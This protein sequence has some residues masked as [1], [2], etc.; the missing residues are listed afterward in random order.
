MTSWGILETDLGDIRDLGDVGDVIVTQSD[1]AAPAEAPAK[2]WK[3]TRALGR[4]IWWPMRA[5]WWA[6]RQVDRAIGQWWTSVL[7]WPWPSL[8]LGAVTI[9]LAAVTTIGLTDNRNGGTISAIAALAATTSVI[10]V[11]A[12]RIEGPV[13]FA[14][15]KFNVAARQIAKVNEESDRAKTVPLH[16]P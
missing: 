1:V 8:W 9:W 11:F 6:L 10:A 3:K 13:S 2:E 7:G 14:G 4:A 12:A 16:T 15:N 5:L